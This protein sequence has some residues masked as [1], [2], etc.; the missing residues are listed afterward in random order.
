MSKYSVARSVSFGIVVL[1]TIATNSKILAA[2][3][4]FAFGMMVL[5]VSGGGGDGTCT[6]TRCRM[7]LGLSIVFTPH[8]PLIIL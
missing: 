5:R 8:L 2:T 7:T 4:E 6:C 3:F 1:V